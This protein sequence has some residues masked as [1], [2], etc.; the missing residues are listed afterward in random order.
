MNI[1]L[2][3]KNF[4]K[5]SSQIELKDFD[6]VN[7][8]VGK[9]GS[10]KSSILNALSFLNDETNA[11]HFF[12]I[13]SVVN[14]QINEKEHKLVWINTNPNHVEKRASLNIEL[15]VFDDNGNEKGA[16]GIFRH[17]FNYDSV[18]KD[19]LNF[20]NETAN[21]LGFTPIKAERIIDNNDPWSD[22]VGKRVFKQDEVLL[23]LN[24]LSQGFKA[25]NDIRSIILNFT[26]NI[27]TKQISNTDAIFVIIEEPENNLHPELQKKVP[28][29]FDQILNEIPLEIRDKI[30]F[31]VSTHSP[32]LIG[33]SA[34]YENQKV[35]L[36]SDGSPM[37]L[38]LKK[39]N[40]SSGYNGIQ[41]SWIVAQMLGSDITDFGYPENY[42]I[43][44][45]Y[46][47]QLILEGLKS[48]KLIKNIQ[49]VSASG[50]MR[51]V[52]FSETI[53]EILNLNTLVKCNPYYF[54]KYQIIIDSLEEFAPKE[55]E[56]IEKVKSNIGSRFIELK[57]HSL[58]DYYKNIDVEI[59]KNAIEE[60]ATAKGRE[61]GI[62]KSKYANQILNQINT[63]EEFS[64]LFNNE[65]NFLLK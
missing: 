52:N 5:I 24:F 20:I 45:E 47:L 61:K 58:E 57:E 10:G 14:L 49:F 55:K 9:N 18:G 34:N 25:F 8:F 48:K 64:K 42:C 50:A 51:V 32:F 56:R 11:T 43:L 53:N 36:I 12:K 30:F 3:L 39:T 1:S 27:N 60:I 65:L 46:S 29:Y 4:K 62:P 13:D 37:D 38:E 31:F 16:N 23:N 41:C 33:S 15:Y 28:N 63:K 44:E 59:Y 2:K 40:I 21:Y 7:Y 35:Y 17:K 22:D 54:D 26:S 19:Q 6:R